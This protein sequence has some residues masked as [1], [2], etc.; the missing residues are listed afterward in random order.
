MAGDQPTPTQKRT[1]YV[2]A[3]CVAFAVDLVLSVGRGL[4]YR[5]SLIGL[6]IMITAVIWFAWSW[7]RER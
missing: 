4:P 3:F 1:F 6:A 5:P 7:I 2:V